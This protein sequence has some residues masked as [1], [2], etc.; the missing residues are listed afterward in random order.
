[1][2]VRNAANDSLLNCVEHNNV[3]QLSTNPK[4]Q[5]K[6]SWDVGS[7]SKLKIKYLT[8][9]QVKYLTCYTPKV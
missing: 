7:C 6:D 1:M 3:A 5:I 2:R 4:L 8:C 9:L